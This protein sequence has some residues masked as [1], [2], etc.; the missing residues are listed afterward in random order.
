M[1]EAVEVAIES[2]L[3]TRAQ[4]LAT[5]QG[6]TISMPNIAFTPPEVAQASKWLRATFL[7]N[8]TA[9]IGV[10]YSSSNQHFGILQIDVFYGLGSGELAPGRVA[11]AVIEYFKR[12]TVVTKDGFSAQVTKAPTRGKWSTTG[13]G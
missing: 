8:D 10:S 5:A 2:A 9:T 4:A 6:L 3:L 7:P 12:G 1:A 13:P 11:A